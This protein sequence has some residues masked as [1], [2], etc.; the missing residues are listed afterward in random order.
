M[1]TT[2]PIKSL[3]EAAQM[4]EENGGGRNKVPS[5]DFDIV[6]DVGF[7]QPLSS[8]SPKCQS[9]VVYSSLCCMIR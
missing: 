5:S 3:L 7:Q 2:S 4:I 1:L 8:S 6:Y 9:L